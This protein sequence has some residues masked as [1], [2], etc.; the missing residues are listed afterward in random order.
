[1]NLLDYDQ[2]DFQVH[3]NRYR[4][5]RSYLNVVEPYVSKL[6]LLLHFSMIKIAKDLEEIFSSEFLLQN[7]LMFYQLDYIWLSVRL[8]TF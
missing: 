1:M 6:S 2:V 4:K 5:H 3:V 8:K 7:H